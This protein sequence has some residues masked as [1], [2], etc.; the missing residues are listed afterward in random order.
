ME[1][2][3]KDVSL[4]TAESNINDIYA[5]QLFE[6]SNKIYIKNYRKMKAFKNHLK[7]RRKKFYIF[8]VKAPTDR[9]KIIFS[10]PLFF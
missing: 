3:V 1:N 4:S 10:F 8:W 2:V 6:N 9:A 7:M 5:T